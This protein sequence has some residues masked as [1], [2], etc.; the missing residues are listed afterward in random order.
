MLRAENL[1]LHPTCDILQGILV[2]NEVAKLSEKCVWARRQFG[3]S[4]TRELSPCLFLATYLAVEE[5]ASQMEPFDT[6]KQ[7]S[8]GS[9]VTQLHA[10]GILVNCMHYL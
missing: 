5:C 4:Y 7:E 1:G 6:V 3:G 9:F 2:A 10:Y 8:S